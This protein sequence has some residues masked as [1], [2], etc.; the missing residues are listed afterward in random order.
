MAPLA[1]FF[2]SSFC[3]AV[4]FLFGNCKTL[5]QKKT[6]PSL[7]TFT[8]LMWVVM[9][10]FSL[11]NAMWRL[12]RSLKAAKDRK[13]NKIFTVNGILT[14]ESLFLLCLFLHFPAESDLISVK[15]HS[16]RQPF[17]SGNQPLVTRLY[18]SISW[19]LYPESGYKSITRFPPLVCEVPQTICR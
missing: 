5:P 6:G 10:H 18:N 13:H 8:G 12:K 15:K 2:F 11:R 14:F 16:H 19:S 3:C 4:F 17:V 9:Q 1:R 7:H